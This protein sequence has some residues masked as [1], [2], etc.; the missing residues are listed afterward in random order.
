MKQ[1]EK[2]SL[3]LLIVSDIHESMMNVERLEKWYLEITK[4]H[5]IQFD[6]VLVPG[7]TGNVPYKKGETNE[8][9][10][11]ESEGRDAVMQPRW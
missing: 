3:K 10:Q 2:K 9:E 11:I 7:D 8:K 5:P 1:E 4:V 6:Y